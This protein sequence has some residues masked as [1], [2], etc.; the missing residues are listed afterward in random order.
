MILVKPRARVRRVHGPLQNVLSL[1]VFMRD[2][3]VLSSVVHVALNEIA[4]QPATQYLSICVGVTSRATLVT[5]S[6]A[7]STLRAFCTWQVSTL[8][9]SV[10]KTH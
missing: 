6:L 4:L 7:V 2:P 1:P 10:L 8:K 5:Q 9:V 3:S